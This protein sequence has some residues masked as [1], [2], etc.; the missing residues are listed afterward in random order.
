MSQ[1]ALFELPRP[2][3][4]GD[5]WSLG[6]L[7][8]ARTLESR[9]EGEA[10]AGEDRDKAL[11]ANAALLSRVL[12]RKGQPALESVRAVHRKSVV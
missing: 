7:T 11:W 3:E 4:L 10:L 12:L 5:G 2:V 6:F 9:E 8:A 1:R